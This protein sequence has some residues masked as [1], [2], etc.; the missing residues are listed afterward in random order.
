MRGFN[1]YLEYKDEKE[2]KKAT[3]KKPGNHKGTVLAVSTRFD[4]DFETGRW[5]SFPDYHRTGTGYATD[6][7]GALFDQP[8]SIV[9]STQ[10][11][12]EYLRENCKRISEK[13]AREIHPKL[14]E[15]LEYEPPTLEG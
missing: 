7:I 5:S 8:D 6:A 13:M 12:P 9:M 10:V 14:F 4:G 15:Y 2:K 1:F 11:C 3:R